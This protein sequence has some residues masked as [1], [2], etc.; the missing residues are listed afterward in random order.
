M[1]RS[2]HLLILGRREENKKAEIRDLSIA[3]I[4]NLDFEPES[5]YHQHHDSNE[6]MY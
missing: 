6:H 3:R 1:R 2:V 5:L 4:A